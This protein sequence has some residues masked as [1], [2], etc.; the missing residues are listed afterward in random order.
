MKMRLKRRNARDY[1]S[2]PYRSSLAAAAPSESVFA[3][4]SQCASAPGVAGMAPHLIA[5]GEILKDS[6]L[7]LEISNSGVK[8]PQSKIIE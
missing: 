8:F 3:M 4:R 5:V 7:A 2:Q 1:I 6:G